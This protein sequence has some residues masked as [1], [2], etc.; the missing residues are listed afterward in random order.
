[1]RSEETISHG[2]ST[3]TRISFTRENH[4]L[5]SYFVRIFLASSNR[6]NRA[7]AWVSIVKETNKQRNKQKKEKEEEEI[8]KKEKEEKGGEYKKGWKKCRK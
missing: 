6:L 5:H 2:E 3:R 4:V 8:E 1:M 7:V